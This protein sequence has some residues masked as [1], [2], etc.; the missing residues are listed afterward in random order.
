MIDIKTEKLVNYIGITGI[1]NKIIPILFKQA[2]R[3]K[4]VT[5][6]SRC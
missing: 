2:W 6:P 4:Y 3:V 1:N 5:F